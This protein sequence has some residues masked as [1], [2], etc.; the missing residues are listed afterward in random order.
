M[1]NS[2]PT[3]SEAIAA[4]TEAADNMPSELTGYS[5]ADAMRILLTNWRDAEG[6][7]N[8]SADDMLGDLDKVIENL[9]AVKRVISP[10]LAP[11]KTLSPM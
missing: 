4:A 3:K 2:S 5:A 11:R 6:D 10:E 1:A 7:P 9:N 8:F